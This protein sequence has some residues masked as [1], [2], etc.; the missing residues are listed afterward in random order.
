MDEKYRTRERY[1]GT[2]QIKS[3][4]RD[5][6]VERAAKLL[7][8][9]FET[10]DEALGIFRAAQDFL[11]AFDAE[12]LQYKVAQLLENKAMYAAKAKVDSI[13]TPKEPEG[14]VSQDEKFLAGIT[15][16]IEDHISDSDLNVNALSELSG[17][18]G[19]QKY[20]KL[21]QLTGMSPVEYIKSVRM[22]KAAMLLK[23]K[24]FSVSEVM[25]MAGYS[26][27]SY[28]SKCFQAAFGKTPKQYLAETDSQ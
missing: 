3:D 25:Y 17:I 2:L 14:V 27:P 6:V 16:L 12:L 15:Q 28:F 23:Q 7:E 8:N 1:F 5:I 10:L 21:K 20:R 19:K 26:N 24:K 22:K 4:R 13:T 11:N 18:G 9:S